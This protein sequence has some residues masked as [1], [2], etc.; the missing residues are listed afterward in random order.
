MC[1]LSEDPSVIAVTSSYE[2]VETSNE[3]VIEGPPGLI[4]PT[5]V[6][7]DPAPDEVTTPTQD[8]PP[9]TVSSSHFLS[10]CVC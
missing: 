4:H 2:V 8:P 7:H 10:V 6:S 9:V 1:R 3:S 5:V